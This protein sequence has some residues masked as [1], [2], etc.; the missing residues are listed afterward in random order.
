MTTWIKNWAG[1]TMGAS[2][3]TVQLLAPT[4]MDA[5]GSRTFPTNSSLFASR[6]TRC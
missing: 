5:G 6:C 4:L 3:A 1:V 2:K